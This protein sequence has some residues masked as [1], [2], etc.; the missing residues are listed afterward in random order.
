MSLREAATCCSPPKA[1]EATLPSVPR[2]PTIRSMQ[3]LLLIFV[4]G[5]LSVAS[6]SMTAAATEMRFA[7]VIGNAS[8]KVSPLAT[9]INDAGLIAQALQETGFQVTTQH[10]LNEE[11]LRKAFSDFTTRIGKAGPDVVAVV[12]FAGNGLQL[13]GENYLLPVDADMVTVDGARARAVSLSDQMHSL[14]AL[15]LK[16]SVLILDEARENPSS[17]SGSP[18]A[19]GFAWVEPE[20]DMLIAFNAAPGTVVRK[21]R[22]SLGSYAKALAE[23]IRGDS[24]TP[25]ELFER[26]RLRVSELTMGAQVPW[27]ASKI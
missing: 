23:T 21:G 20:P 11:K 16:A 1:C 25:A 12:Y 5:L 19:G 6:Q 4:I 27:N 9:P 2:L 22:D 7:L 26:V 14:A 17:W 8:Y 13:R 15:H 3:R 10:D 18:P 24:Q